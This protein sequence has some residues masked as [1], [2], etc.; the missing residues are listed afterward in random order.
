MN[1]SAP[2]LPSTE[3][4]GLVSRDCIHLFIENKPVIRPSSMFCFLLVDLS[5]IHLSSTDKTRFTTW[6][7]VRAEP[8]EVQTYHCWS[9]VG[10]GMTTSFENTPLLSPAISHFSIK[11]SFSWL[12]SLFRPFTSLQKCSLSRNLLDHQALEMVRIESKNS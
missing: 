12:Y 4:W 3:E 1:H 9:D 5:S 11:C 2:R 10:M 7:S 6:R 8:Q